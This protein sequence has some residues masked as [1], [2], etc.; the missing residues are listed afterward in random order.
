MNNMSKAQLLAFAMNL[1]NLNNL[2]TSE[3]EELKRE[4]KKLKVLL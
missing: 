4:L 2:L 1:V 3:N